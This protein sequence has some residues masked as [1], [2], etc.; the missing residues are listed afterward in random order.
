MSDMDK[1]QLIES[2]NEVDVDYITEYESL[3]SY[4]ASKKAIRRRRMRV[5]ARVAACL[6]IVSTG[7]FL[8]VHDINNGL[9]GRPSKEIITN[10]DDRYT[11]M[12][13][14]NNNGTKSENG[15]EV[16]LGST[17][18]NGDYNQAVVCH[19]IRCSASQNDITV[20]VFDVD[21]ETL[22]LKYIV[23]NERGAKWYTGPG[24]VVYDLNTEP[25]EM[26]FNNHGEA[27]DYLL[28]C[29]EDGVCTV[30]Y[31]WG[32][33]IGALPDGD[34]MIRALLADRNVK[35]EVDTLISV[36]HGTK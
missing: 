31:E 7:V 36:N 11:I 8:T 13:G 26:Y 15:S 33:S 29:D 19:E 30:V 23:N 12:P 35:Y 24:V 28:N 2:L 20:S 34:Y 27:T 32:A 25:Y 1:W 3:S 18:A 14:T 10:R 16:V 5:A 4:I 17:G 6:A 21:E 22:T 9:I